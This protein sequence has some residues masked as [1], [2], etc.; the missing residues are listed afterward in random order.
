M[1]FSKNALCPGMHLK[2]LVLH[3]MGEILDQKAFFLS[4]V[5]SSTKK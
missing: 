1:H 2:K 4:F 3:R 5:F